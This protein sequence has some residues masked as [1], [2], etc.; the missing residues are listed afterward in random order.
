MQTPPPESVPT[1]DYLN[2]PLA[3]RQFYSWREYQWMS[4]R[5]KAEIVARNCEPEPE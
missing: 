4:E 2:L 3:I 1:A 5:Q